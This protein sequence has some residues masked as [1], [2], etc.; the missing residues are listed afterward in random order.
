MLRNPAISHR[1]SSII[2][3]WPSSAKQPTLTGS[4]IATRTDGAATLSS[5]PDGGQF[6]GGVSTGRPG[7]AHPRHSPSC[8][9][10]SLVALDSPFP[11]RTVGSLAVERRSRADLLVKCLLHAPAR[12]AAPQ[13]T[14]HRPQATGEEATLTQVPDRCSLHPAA[15]YPQA[16]AARWNGRCSMRGTKEPCSV[17]GRDGSGRDRSM[18]AG[19]R[20]ARPALTRISLDSLATRKSDGIRCPMHVAPLPGALAELL[21]LPAPCSGDRV[22]SN[23][24][25]VMTG[26]FSFSFPSVFSGD[27]LE[28]AVQMYIWMHQCVGSRQSGPFKTGSRRMAGWCVHVV[29]ETARAGLGRAL[30][31]LT[32]RPS[33]S[34]NP[35]KSPGY[36]VVATESQT[37]VGVKPVWGGRLPLF[38]SAS[39]SVPSP[40]RTRA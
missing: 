28:Y 30:L 35:K 17:S 26:A 12:G 9:Q 1:L 24:R 21:F 14:G 5:C 33:P 3:W 20:R 2:H 31:A 10:A 22:A 23:G 27:V 36:L 11:R 7:S 18:N 38:R 13:A 19:P 15:R 16:A 40:A 34:M 37:L 25:V 32:S 29:L 39:L 6:P 8:N 4:W